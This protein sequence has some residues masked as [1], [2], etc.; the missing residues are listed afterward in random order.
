M[1]FTCFAS[2]DLA[3][4]MATHSLLKNDVAC[5]QFVDDQQL[6]EGLDC[7]RKVYKT[8][9][10]YYSKSSTDGKTLSKLIV[11]LVNSKLICGLESE[12][13]AQITV[14]NT[15]E[16]IFIALANSSDCQVKAKR[17]IRANR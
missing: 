2:N 6:D 11:E 15:E 5:N 8:L 9:E 10:T 16:E 13:A 12:R 14:D 3:S 4:T 7:V 17:I 1:S